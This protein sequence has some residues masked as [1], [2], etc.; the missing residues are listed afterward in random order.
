MPDYDAIIKAVENDKPLPKNVIDIPDVKESHTSYINSMQE[1]NE[2]IAQLTELLKTGS[3]AIKNMEAALKAADEER[4]R[5]ADQRREQEPKFERVGFEETYYYIR[6]VNNGTF[7]IENSIDIGSEYSTSEFKNNNYFHTKERAQE[8][9]DKIN[10]LLKLERLYDTFCPDYIPDWND[11]ELEFKYFV[12]YDN[13]DKCY[14]VNS[15]TSA[16]CKTN[17][18]FPT[19]EIAEKVCDILNAELEEKSNKS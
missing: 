15:L 2:R 3:E 19:L 4:D 10:F 16:E 1:L 13:W 12:T 14:R 17:V 6:T 18:F 5:L 9:V 8:V 11:D 7:R